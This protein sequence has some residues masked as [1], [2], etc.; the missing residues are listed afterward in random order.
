MDADL[1]ALEDQS[2]FLLREA[3]AKFR[4]VAML[5]S[6]GKDSTVMLALCRAAFF[7]ACPFPAIHIDNGLDFPETYELRERVAREWGVTVLVAKSLVQP[8]GI[9]GVSCCGA[10]KTEALKALMAQRNFDALVVSIRR[11][12]HGIRSKERYFSPRDA[13]FRWAYQEQPPDVLHHFSAPEGTSHVRVH[14]LLHWT[15]LDIWRYIQACGLPVHPLYF[16]KAGR[17]FRSLGCTRCTVAVP[18]AAAT[19]E[20][21][22]EELRTTQTPERTGRAQDKER[23]YVMQRLR[24]LGYM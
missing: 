21:I 6:T 7:G 9:S 22:I 13:D 17:R 1:R 19:V 3:K 18:S 2:V 16:A 11:D 5:W 23:E 4:N 20:A 14:P 15:E 8:D 10:N 12:E 24:A